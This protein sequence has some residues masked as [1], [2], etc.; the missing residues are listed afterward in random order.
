MQPI[1]IKAYA[2][3]FPASKEQKNILANIC[4]QAIPSASCERE[5]NLLRVSF[6]GVYFPAD[7]FLAAI[8]TSLSQ[9]QT[10]K[11]DMLDLEAW[12]LDRYLFQDG[13]II[14]KASPLNDV[15]AYSG[16]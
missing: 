4:A 9:S 2:N 11:L 8:A 14:H 13:K 15:L 5:D 16:H 6:E 10:G 7:E 3:L 1:I 12:R